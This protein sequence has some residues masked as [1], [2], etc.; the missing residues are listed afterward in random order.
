[1]EELEGNHEKIPVASV[2]GCS[3]HS[4]HQSN[5]KITTHKKSSSVLQNKEDN[6]YEKTIVTR[7]AKAEKR[8]NATNTILNGISWKLSN[9]KDIKFRSKIYFGYHPLVNKASFPSKYQM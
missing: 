1:M 5:A 4:T 6:I 9:G 8:L 2:S 7:E 3:E